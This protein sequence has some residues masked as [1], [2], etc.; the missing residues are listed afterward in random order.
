VVEVRARRLDRSSL[1]PLFVF[2]RRDK[3]PEDILHERSSDV[4]LTLRL[5]NR[6]FPNGVRLQAVRIAFTPRRTKRRPSTYSTRTSRGRDVNSIRR[7][8]S[9]VRH[10]HLS[11]VG[12]HI[13]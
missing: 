7:H 2:S 13:R 4:P 5:D 6:H 12:R 8:P 9:I 11:P 1:R 3:R 10:L